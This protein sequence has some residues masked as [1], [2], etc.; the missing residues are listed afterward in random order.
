MSR[1]AIM[2]W[3]WEQTGHATTLTLLMFFNIGTAVV[4]SPLA[5]VVVDRFDRRKVMIF[6]SGANALVTVALLTL[7]LSGHLRLAHVYAAAVTS[8]AFETFQFPA[9]SAAVTMMV[10]RRHYARTSGLISL[11]ESASRILGPPLA[12]VLLPLVGIPVI[13]AIELGTF[14]AVIGC[15][16]AVEVPPPPA[17]REGGEPAGL[18]RQA[19]FGLRY[20]GTHRGL[21]AL[22]L[23]LAAGNFL[24]IFGV[25]LRAPLVLA[26]T[27]GDQ[28]LLGVVMAAAGA[29]GVTGGLLMAAWGGPRR[30]I[31]GVV[32]GLALGAVG[33]VIL[34]CGRQAA[35][36]FAGSFAYPLAMTLTNASNQAIWQS[37]VAPGVQGRVFAARRLVAQFTLLP[38]LLLAGPLSDR[39][40]EPLLAAGGRGAGALAAVVGSGAGAGI[41]LLTAATAALALAVAAAGWASRTVREVESALPDHGEGG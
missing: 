4:L 10:D 7:Y 24:L 13:F 1:F 26:R 5:G 39:L 29:G 8:G 12:G 25:T 34:G 21:L 15:L 17:S 33:N 38:G 40:F 31:A 23:L 41:G 6:A 36:W 18:W 35:A 30:R 20:I 19:V 2:I 32:G 28:A 37:K 14:A 3:G 22:Q 16:A 11:A 27:G 9:Y